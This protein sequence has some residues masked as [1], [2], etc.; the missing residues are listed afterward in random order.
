MSN[1]TNHNSQ[2]RINGHGHLLPS[3]QDIP[4]FMKDK[5]FFWVDE[6]KAFMCQ[7]DWKRPI[8]DPSFFLEEKIAWM[9]AN[10]IDHE[11]ILSLSQL[12]CNGINEQDTFDII[13]F[14][15]DFNASVQE[16]HPHLFTTGFVVQPAHM[17]QALNEIER[18]HRMGMKFLCLSTHYQTTNGE[19]LSVCDK[20]VEP[21]W[22]LADTLKLAIEIHPYDAGKMVN[23]TDHFWRYHLV[24]M[25][26]QTADTHLMF[27]Y[28][29]FAQKYPNVRTSFAHGSMLSQANF[30]RTIQGIEGRPDLFPNAHHPTETLKQ[31]NVFFDTL[32]HDI[33]TLELMIKRN[34]VKQIIWG[35][36]DPYPLGEMATVDGCYPG[37]LFDQAIE[38]GV[39]SKTDC[40]AMM[41]QNVINW[42]GFEPR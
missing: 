35:V 8:T 42:L 28:N 22:Q 36:D 16:Q 24:W 21:I 18:C 14:Q 26:A 38:A 7:G 2:Y 17:E 5:K 11:V 6:N 29:G 25:M 27:T 4:A 20:S 9:Q 33:H 1:K 34:G 10:N 12:Y 32:V 39:L 15:N 23:L 41:G 31:S 19:W 13:R 37:V 30:G 40:E 3:P